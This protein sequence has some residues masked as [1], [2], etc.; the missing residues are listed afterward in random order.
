MGIWSRIQKSRKEDLWK[1]K[2]NCGFGVGYR[3]VKKKIYGRGR[4]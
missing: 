1:R 4:V 2:G 3:R